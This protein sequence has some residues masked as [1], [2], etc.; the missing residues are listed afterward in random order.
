VFGGLES[1]NYEQS[2]NKVPF[3]GD[4]PILGHLFKT[5][6]WSHTKSK[7]YIFVRATIFTNDRSLTRV[8]EDLRDQAHVLAEQDEWIPPVVSER[9]VRAPG[10]TVQDEVFDVFGTGSGNPFGASPKDE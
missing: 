2:E 4:V 1:E 5:K 7:I 8:S 3:L 6:T 9:L 10:R